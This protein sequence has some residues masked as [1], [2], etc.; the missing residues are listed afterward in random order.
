MSVANPSQPPGGG[1][2]PT[3][4]PQ[5]PEPFSLFDRERDH[6]H[7]QEAFREMRRPDVD[8]RWV[9]ATNWQMDHRVLAER[10]T[11]DLDACGHFAAV[12]NADDWWEAR[13]RYFLEEICRPGDAAGTDK[14]SA[15]GRP[16]NSGNRITHR[17]AGF[18]KLVHVGSFNA[19]LRRAARSDRAADVETT[20]RR[21]TGQGLP[22]RDLGAA[23]DPFSAQVSTLARAL[24]AQGPEALRQVAGLLVD[25]LGEEEPPWWAGFAEEIHS[26]LDSRSATALCTALGLGHRVPGDWLIVWIYPIDEAGTL[27][28]PTA[29]E[30]N[31]SP[32]HF[33]SPPGHIVGVTMP[34]DPR[35]AACREVLHRPLRGPAAGEY[36]TGELLL[37]ESLPL[38]RDNKALADLRTQHRARLRMELPSAGLDAWL[39]RHPEIT[40]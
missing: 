7:W 9:I 26:A 17:I 33:P 23:R 3:P 22:S 24:T 4:A 30:A 36:C 10:E 16:A 40:P 32:Y 8:R 13:E 14:T 34:L 6:H 38:L 15:Y 29:V 21:L 37:L 27:Y 5:A 31:D 18:D 11:G 2:L 12:G 39:D 20:M 35:L 1:N 28:R 25:S 19:L